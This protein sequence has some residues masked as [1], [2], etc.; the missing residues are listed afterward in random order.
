MECTLVLDDLEA[1]Y[2]RI[3]TMTED[4]NRE[5]E[6]KLM[7]A[8]RR[9]ISLKTGRDEEHQRQKKLRGGNNRNLMLL[10]SEIFKK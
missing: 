2:S 5:Y 9:T 8:W 7:R 4:N 6:G 3:I 1:E 10:A